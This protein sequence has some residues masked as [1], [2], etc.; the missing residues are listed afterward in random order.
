M[1]IVTLVGKNFVYNI[2]NN[3]PELNMN[4]LHKIMQI[5]LKKKIKSTNISYPKNYPQVEP[6]RRCPDIS[7]ARSIGYDPDVA[8]EDGLHR[9]LL[10]YQK[11]Q[12]LR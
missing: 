5:A 7:K 8:L 11:F 1:F 3:K 10:W 6:Q 4:K 12:L 2:G 9:T